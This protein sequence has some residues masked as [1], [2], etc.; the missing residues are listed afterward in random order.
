MSSNI[1]EY[2]IRLYERRTEPI[3][4][5]LLSDP[6][7]KEPLSHRLLGEKQSWTRT[8]TLLETYKEGTI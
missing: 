3:D 6:L 4:E 2:L 1:Q 8:D 7:L 5:G